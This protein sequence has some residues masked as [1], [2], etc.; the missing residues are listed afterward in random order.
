MVVDDSSAEVLSE[1]SS[2][3]IIKFLWSSQLP[4]EGALGLTH[5]S[6][7]LLME[8]SRTNSAV[9]ALAVSSPRGSLA[10]SPLRKLL[11]TF[12]HRPEE[13]VGLKKY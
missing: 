12:T 8:S 4:V 6:H 3:R 10:L 1:C 7:C 9:S 13:S 11:F 2:M 5:R